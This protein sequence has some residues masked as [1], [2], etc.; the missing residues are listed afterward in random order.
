MTGGEKLRDT[1][2]I[3]QNISRLEVAV[4]DEVPMCVIYCGAY[5]QKQSEAV[6]EAELTIGAKP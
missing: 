4:D 1:L 5:L 3:D 2:V 6:V